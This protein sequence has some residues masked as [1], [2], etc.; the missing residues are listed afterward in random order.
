MS[1]LWGDVRRDV[2]RRLEEHAPTV[3]FE[4]RVRIAE[5]VARE[6]L[7]DAELFAVP[8]RTIGPAAV[9]RALR[10]TATSC[11]CCGSGC[12]C[13]CVLEC[14]VHKGTDRTNGPEPTVAEAWSQIDGGLLDEWGADRTVG[15]PGIPSRGRVE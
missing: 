9:Q 10:L 11:E 5:D 2:M 6:V 4:D 15:T 7:L 1:D 3:P 8:V 13:G 14:P 12:D